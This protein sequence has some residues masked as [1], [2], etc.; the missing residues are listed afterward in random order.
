M[1]RTA[2]SNAKKSPDK[3]FNAFKEFWD[4]ETEAHIL[5]KWMDFVG[6]QSFEGNLI[7]AYYSFITFR[8]VF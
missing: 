3:D 1:N 2:K 8:A 7:N 5:G 4:R 6:L